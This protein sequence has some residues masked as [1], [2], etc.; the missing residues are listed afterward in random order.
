MNGQGES[1]LA[2]AMLSAGIVRPPFGSTPE[3]AISTYGRWAWGSRNVPPFE[4]YMFQVD[5]IARMLCDD[6]PFFA[7]NHA[8]HGSNSYALNLV[9]AAGTMAVFVQHPYGG[10]YSDP[11]A[12]LIAINT[13][14]TRLRVLFQAAEG[15]EDR[16]LKWLLIYSRLR[17]T[18]SIVDLDRIR[19]G[20]LEHGSYES[21]AVDDEATLFKAAAER[22]GG[23]DFFKNRQISWLMK[24]SLDCFRE[25]R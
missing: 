7:L 6:G 25:R 21:I 23:N 5:L 15:H 11:L 9:T 17:R 24:L 3:S 2:S 4:M 20:S 10:L 19:G 14:Y 13:T 1:D 12:D 22:F 16:P 8:G 18:S